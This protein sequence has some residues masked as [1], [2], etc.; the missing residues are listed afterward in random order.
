MTK[1]NLYFS[2]NSSEFAILNELASHAEIALYFVLKKHSSFTNATVGNFGVGVTYESLAK[3]ISRP[4][5]QGKAAVEFDRKQVHRLLESLQQKKLVSNIKATP[6]LTLKLPL[7]LLHLKAGQVATDA[8]NSPEDVEGR[9]PQENQPNTPQTLEV[10]D[11]CPFDEESS[12]L[13][14]STPTDNPQHTNQIL[15]SSTKT[16]L[17]GVRTPSGPHRAIHPALKP[18]EGGVMRKTQTEAGKAIEEV[19]TKTG[20]FDW[21]DGGKSRENYERWAALPGFTLGKLR[22]AIALIDDEFP[23]GTHTPIELSKFVGTVCGASGA[24]AS[25]KRSG[26]I[27]HNTATGRVIL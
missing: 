18:V 3:A 24:R 14:V 10:L 2:F 1:K 17:Q 12:I 6:K 9:L 13:T 16:N 22:E 5:T 4:S 21:I 27:H 20:R 11:D 7:S 26:P 15:S 25:N 23:M 19:L 8:A